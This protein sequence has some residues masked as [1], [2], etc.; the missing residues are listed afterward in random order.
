MR[1]T[2]A[3]FWDFT[4]STSS[5]QWMFA[6]KRLDGDGASLRDTEVASIIKTCRYPQSTRPTVSLR[7][8][9]YFASKHG[10]YKA[11]KLPLSMY[12]T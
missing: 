10:V 9:E 5:A 12:L 8:K 1:C 6:T 3:V 11:L 4:I 2:T 7:P